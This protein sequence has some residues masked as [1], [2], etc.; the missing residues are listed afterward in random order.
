MPVPSENFGHP[1]ADV[2]SKDFVAH[3]IPCNCW[4]FDLITHDRPVVWV[5]N[6]GLSCLIVQEEVVKSNAAT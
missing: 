4:R 1:E 3:L 5:K 2:S 6:S